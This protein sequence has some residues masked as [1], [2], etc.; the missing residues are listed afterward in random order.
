MTK[1][2]RI[3]SLLAAF[4]LGWSLSHA[5]G[6]DEGG[7]ESKDVGL[8]YLALYHAGK[9]AELR[10]FLTDE[11]VMEDPTTESMGSALRIV[12]G[13]Q[14]VKQL[15]ELFAASGNFEFTPTHEYQAGRFAV[16][17]GVFTYDVP[18]AM[19]GSDKETVQAGLEVATIV[20]LDGDKV[21]HHADYANYPGMVE[22]MREASEQ[23]E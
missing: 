17:T 14:I 20:E 22:A 13:D 12:G 1:A 2:I 18:G 9:I 3:M 7:A 8:E 11:S 16:S 19:A 23:D 6:S 4:A 21:V 5:Q 15:S 10:P